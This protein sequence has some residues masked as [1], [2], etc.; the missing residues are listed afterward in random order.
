MPGLDQA[1][2]GALAGVAGST[3]S[4]IENGR[5]STRELV[6]AVRRALRDKG[7]NLTFGNNQ[8]GAA[9]CS[10]DRNAEDDE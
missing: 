1:G 4:N 5:N 10:V 9:I 3:V 2:L 8:A 7:V 6:R